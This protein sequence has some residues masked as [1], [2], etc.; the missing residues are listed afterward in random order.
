[1]FVH[2][3]Q[4]LRFP[5]EMRDHHA[6]QFRRCFGNARSDVHVLEAVAGLRFRFSHYKG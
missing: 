2:P 4:N 5:V 1:M 3:D 6:G